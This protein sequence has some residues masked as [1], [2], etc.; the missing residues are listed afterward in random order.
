[1]LMDGVVVD[2]TLGPQLER[3]SSCDEVAMKKA[4][5]TT[6]QPLE[7][8]PRR[9]ATGHL[10]PEYEAELLKLTQDRHSDDGSKA[11]VARPNSKDELAEKLGEEVV[12][13]ATSGEKTEED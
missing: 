2:G 10:Y 9:D 13:A 5:K 6:T 7:V 11:F 1:M 8:F 3:H 4:A 12:Q